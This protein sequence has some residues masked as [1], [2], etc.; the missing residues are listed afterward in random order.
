M[1]K[2]IGINERQLQLSLRWLSDDEEEKRRPGHKGQPKPRLRLIED[3]TPPEVAAR[4]APQPR[5]YVITPAARK[6][7][8]GR[9]A[10]VRDSH[11]PDAGDGEAVTPDGETFTP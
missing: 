9:A 2:R 11:E 6:L 3:V 7:I 5:H 4:K 10:A 8:E 1:T